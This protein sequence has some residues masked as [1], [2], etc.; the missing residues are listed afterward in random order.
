MEKTLKTVCDNCGKEIT[1]AKK[2]HDGQTI[3]LVQGLFC[4]NVPGF[5]CERDCFDEAISRMNGFDYIEPDEEG[6]PALEVDVMINETMLLDRLYDI[7]YDTE[8]NPLFP[9]VLLQRLL[10]VDPENVRFL[11]GLASLYVGLLAAKTI[12]E[13]WKPK[14]RQRL[15]EVEEDLKGLSQEGYLRLQRVKEHFGVKTQSHM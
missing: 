10:M 14:I 3:Y 7:V 9:T 15:T 13:D 1:V 12:P 6:R 5:F 8:H 11:Y 2:L 4:I